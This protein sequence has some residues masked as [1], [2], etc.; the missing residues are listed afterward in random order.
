MYISIY[1][2]ILIC[3]IISLAYTIYSYYSDVP[4]I[5]IQEIKLNQN[6]I[7]QLYGIRFIHYFISK[8]L[9]NFLL[10]ILIFEIYD[11][12]TMVF[13]SLFSIFLLIGI[14]TFF[15]ILG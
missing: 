1:N 9:L 4:R 7:L 10:I 3:I 6:E 5:K 13:V 8:V 11:K 12:K 14:R 15:I 2:V